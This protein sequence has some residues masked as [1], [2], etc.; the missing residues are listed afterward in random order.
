MQIIEYCNIFKMK[1]TSLTL[2]DQNLLGYSLLSFK[3]NAYRIF[4][5][6]IKFQSFKQ[7][8]SSEQIN[9]YSLK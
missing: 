1:N 7:F 3:I 8:V 4:L 9:L 6:N 2:I 5:K